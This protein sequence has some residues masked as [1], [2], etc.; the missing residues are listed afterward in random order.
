M[1]RDHYTLFS[2]DGIRDLRLPNRWREGRGGQ[3]SECVSCNSCL[4]EMYVYPGQKE[5]GSDRCE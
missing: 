5:P 1:G 4:F 3:L 2:E